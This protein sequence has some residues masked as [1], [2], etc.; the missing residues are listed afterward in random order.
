MTEQS[1]QSTT[2]TSEEE[3]A[4][5]KADWVEP[6]KKWHV[7]WTAANVEGAARMANWNPPQGPGEAVFSVMDDGTVH[8]FLYF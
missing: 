8:V 3:V 7:G 5:V 4:R 6:T 1:D 2:I